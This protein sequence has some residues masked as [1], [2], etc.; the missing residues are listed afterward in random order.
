MSLTLVYLNLYSILPLSS[1]WSISHA[2]GRTDSAYYGQCRGRQLHWNEDFASATDNTQC[3]SV[4]PP[5]EGNCSTR[6]CVHGQCAYVNHPGTSSNVL[7]LIVVLNQFLQF[8]TIIQVRYVGGH[9]VP[10]MCAVP[11]EHA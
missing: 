1:L 5:A 2:T 4:L 11:M 3:N 8:I 6:Q 10:H 7:S 9:F